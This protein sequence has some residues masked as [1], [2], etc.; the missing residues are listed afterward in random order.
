VSEQRSL[1]LGTRQDAFSHFVAHPPPPQL[2][3]QVDPLVHVRLHPPLGQEKS[4]VEPLEHS[5]LQGCVVP[6]VRLQF[7]P[8]V[9]VQ[10]L[11]ATQF[12]D[13]AVLVLVSLL[14]PLMRTMTTMEVAIAQS[15][16]PMS[17]V[18]V[19]PLRLPPFSKERVLDEERPRRSVL[20]DRR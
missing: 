2:S 8:A 16:R 5:K 11:P 1:Q 17:M 4:H 12:D 3:V 13:P 19:C 9:H 15:P 20:Q 6:H 18:M 7:E 10:S 14:H